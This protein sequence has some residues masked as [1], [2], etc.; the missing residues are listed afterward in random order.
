[1]QKSA[2][3]ASGYVTD[4]SSSESYYSPSTSSPSSS[5][6]ESLSGSQ[7]A[8]SPVVPPLRWAVPPQ[9][10]APTGPLPPVRMT[11]AGAGSA[12]RPPRPSSAEQN[13]EGLE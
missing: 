10:P 12:V 8:R 9:S 13:F 2:G 5:D 6:S 7:G 1:V 11:G 4:V 3:G